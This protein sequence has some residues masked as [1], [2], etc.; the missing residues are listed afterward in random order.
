MAGKKGYHQN[1]VPV[2]NFKFDKEADEE[3]R[4]RMAPQFGA[5]PLG[6]VVRGEVFKTRR[7][8]QIKR[9]KAKGY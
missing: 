2:Q 5:D 9:R 6:G 8:V 1:A 7:D 3:V 4:S